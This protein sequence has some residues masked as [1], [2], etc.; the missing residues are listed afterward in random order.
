MKHG[1]IRSVGVPVIGLE[2]KIGK[3]FELMNRL[4]GALGWL[5]ML[6]EM[7]GIVH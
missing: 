7:K 4:D 1:D 3:V 6:E 5:V 2:A